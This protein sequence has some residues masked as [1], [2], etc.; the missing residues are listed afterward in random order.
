MFGVSVSTICCNIMSN[1]YGESM[2]KK[3][4]LNKRGFWKR[5]LSVLKGLF[6]E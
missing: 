4:V 2:A 6:N 1:F 3:I 5:A